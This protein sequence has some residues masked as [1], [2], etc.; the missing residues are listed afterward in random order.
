MIHSNFVHLHVHSYY[1]L[2]DGASTVDALV[3]Q[4]VSLGM[5]AL[6]LTDHDALY[7]AVPFV[8]AARGAG[9]QPIL[10][11][12]LTMEGGH[13]H[14]RIIHAADATGRAVSD[15][16][17]EQARRHASIEL[18]ERHIAVNLITDL[19]CAAVDPRIEQ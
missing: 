11:A 19:L 5:P 6:A 16:L 13:S 8:E 18:F 2:L 9:I 1:S 12:E 15:T 7:G 14:R 3:A 10:G 17:I 4:A